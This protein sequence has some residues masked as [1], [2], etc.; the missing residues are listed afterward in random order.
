M[1][2]AV[3]LWSWRLGVSSARLARLFEVLT[4]PERERAE[5]FRF[6]RHRNAFIV[7]RGT[8]RE[9]IASYLGCPPA[10]VEFAYGSHGKPSVKGIHFNLSHSSEFALAAFS[11]DFELGVDVEGI[12]RRVDLQVAQ[13]FFSPAEVERLFAL[14][15]AERSE[16]FLRIWTRKEAVIKAFGKGLALPLSGFDVTIERDAARLLRCEWEASAPETWGMRDV[17][18]AG[19]YIAAIA[20]PVREFELV[21]RE[22]TEDDGAAGSS[23]GG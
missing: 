9:L 23:G 3:Q 13:R 21:R 11:Q 14:P 17:S 22:V 10:A 18:K 20:A 4:P 12:D 1:A 15:E 5:R 7:A 19:E 6:D 2:S 16:G 8:L